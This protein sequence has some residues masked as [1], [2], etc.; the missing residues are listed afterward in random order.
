[1][2]VVLLLLLLFARFS[3]RSLFIMINPLE[4]TYKKRKIPIQDTSCMIWFWSV[5]RLIRSFSVVIK[6]FICFDWQSKPITIKR[7]SLVIAR[8]VGLSIQVISNAWSSAHFII[9]IHYFM[10]TSS[11]TDMDVTDYL[12][13]HMR[14]GEVNC[15]RA[16][17]SGSTR[18]THWQPCSLQIVQW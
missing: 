14:Q 4:Q 11:I 16:S 7:W 18:H 1:M 6:P 2:S 8:F 9:R 15:N 3:K 17:Y 5:T 10:S 13:I 12:G